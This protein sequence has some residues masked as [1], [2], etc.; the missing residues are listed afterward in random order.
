MPV[1]LP[2]TPYQ[3]DLLRQ[4]L[5][6]P[7]NGRLTPQLE[8]ESPHGLARSAISAI[9]RGEDPRPDA[10]ASL[11]A[12]L[13]WRDAWAQW[14]TA[15]APWHTMGSR[16]QAAERAAETASARAGTAR[17][18]LK[19]YGG[20]L[21]QLNEHDAALRLRGAFA[22]L[23]RLTNA[24]PEAWLLELSDLRR[25][26]AG[27]IAPNQPIGPGG[28]RLNDLDG[29]AIEDVPREPLIAA[30][31]NV[32][33]L[34]GLS[35]AARRWATAVS[36]PLLSTETAA[37]AELAL[38][39]AQSVRAD[40]AEII[41]VEAIEAMLAA[42]GQ[43]QAAGVRISESSSSTISQMQSVLAARTPLPEPLD[44]HGLSL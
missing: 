9:R 36:R 7:K 34:D 16:Q 30:Y 26:L 24:S 44:T 33:W 2:P 13:A 25:S 37:Q 1:T 22:Q 8:S 6:E 31:A 19:W 41:G 35:R 23:N 29:Q 10:Q 39:T 12:V 4:A 18:C 5:D 17:S 21:G 42:A 28:L 11:D 14:W 32:Y 40:P 3:Q 15:Q 27:H 20:Q 43:A 38:Q